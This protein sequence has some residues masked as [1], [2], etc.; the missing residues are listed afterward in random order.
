MIAPPVEPM[1][2]VPVGMQ[3]QP[4]IP[5]AVEVPSATTVLLPTVLPQDVP[6]PLP[7]DPAK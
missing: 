7:S 2:I 1:P 6:V 5:P 3:I 4:V